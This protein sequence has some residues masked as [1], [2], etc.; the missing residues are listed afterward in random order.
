M[1]FT[2]DGSRMCLTLLVQP[3]VTPHQ[4]QH[5][6]QHGLVIRSW[7][8]RIFH[9][10]FRGAGTCTCP[11]APSHRAEASPATLNGGFTPHQAQGTLCKHLQNCGKY[12][13]LRQKKMT[14]HALEKSLP[15]ST[16]RKSRVFLEDL[17]PLTG[18]LDCDSTPWF[19]RPARR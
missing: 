3:P 13:K 8:G 4:V 5:R 12:G 16:F 2:P 1:L 11:Q 7:T 10:A 15:N 6:A 14:N 19:F 9:L 17:D 18:V